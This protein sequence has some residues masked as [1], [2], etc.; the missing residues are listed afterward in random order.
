MAG[1]GLPVDID[2]TYA[3]DGLDASV[4]AHQH[5]HDVVHALV[6]AIDTRVPTVP[7]ILGGVGHNY[8]GAVTT[9]TLT[10]DD[11]GINVEIDG[12]AAAAVTVPPSTA[13]AF[14]VGT[15]VEVTALGTG[16]VTIQAGVGVTLRTPGTLVLRAQNSTIRLRKRAADTWVLSGDTT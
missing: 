2:A 13:V 11:A 8:L 10:L 7:V 12:S 16:Q 15:V 3:D 6:N 1:P 4:Q 14:T 5:A 9:Y